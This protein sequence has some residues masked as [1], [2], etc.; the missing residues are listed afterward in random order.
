MPQHTARTLCAMSGTNFTVDELLAALAEKWGEECTVRAGGG[1]WTAEKR[2]G[3][4]IHLI[5]SPEIWALDAQMTQLGWQP[6]GT[7][8]AWKLAAAM[9]R[10]FAG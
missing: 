4:A 3:T 7:D 10:P 1:I 9:F 8:S 2:S 6:K 5:V